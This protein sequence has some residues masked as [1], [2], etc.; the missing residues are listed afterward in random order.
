MVLENDAA[1]QV[2]LTASLCYQFE[3]H[4]LGIAM[5]SVRCTI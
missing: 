3:L 5:R 2:E 1:A 4:T